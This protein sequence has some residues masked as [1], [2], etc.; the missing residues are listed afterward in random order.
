MKI[1]LTATAA[2]CAVATL[3]CV[4]FAAPTTVTTPACEVEEVVTSAENDNPNL[5]IKFFSADAEEISAM[6]PLIPGEIHTTPAVISAM[7]AETM[8]LI[9]PSQP[10]GE[11]VLPNTQQWSLG[12]VVTLYFIA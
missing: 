1:K 4:A 10:Q 3:F 12:Q 9:I 11:F 5:D 8:T 2:L 7:D 6:S